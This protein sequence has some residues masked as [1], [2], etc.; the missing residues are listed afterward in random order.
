M[1]D[2]ITSSDS[3]S[4]IPPYAQPREQYSTSIKLNKT[5]VL[6]F[7]GTGDQFDS[8]NSNVVEFFSLL[9][10]DNHDEQMVYYQAMSKVLDAMVAWNLDAHVISGYKFLMQ[11]CEIGLSSI[12]RSKITPSLSLF[13]FLG[14]HPFVDK[15]GDKI[16]LFGFSRG[17]YTARALAGML[18]KVGLLPPDNYQQVPFAYKMYKRTDSLGWEQSKRDTVCSVGL[19]HRQLPFTVSNTAIRVFRHALSLDERRA[20]FKANHYNR[21]DLGPTDETQKSELTAAAGTTSVATPD[22]H[23]VSAM[24][25]GGIGQRPATPANTENSG[26]LLSSK[27]RGKQ[28]AEL[29]EKNFNA[30]QKRLVQETDVKE[31]WFAGC[32]CDVGGGSVLDN[33]E[34]SLARISLRWMIREV[35]RTNTGIHFSSKLLKSI[36]LDPASLWPEAKVAD[37]PPPENP[38]T[39]KTLPFTPNLTMEEIEEEVKD[40]MCPIYDQ[41]RIKP[42]WWLLEVLPSKQHRNEQWWKVLN[43]ALV[44]VHGFGPEVRV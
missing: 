40:A 12:S 9:S 36:G 23:A 28:Q 2:N 43:V 17:A 20:K 30:T 4:I 35:F 16:S 42:G 26:D 34:N 18:H 3:K 41:L 25:G 33:V 44:R 32:H 8:D 21:A 15:E 14:F 29:N 31:V 27:S 11:N 24:E 39:S 38:H 37:E 22:T 7:D 19:I 1:G 10:R 6:C 5:L 13:P